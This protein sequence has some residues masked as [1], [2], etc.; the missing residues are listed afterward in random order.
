MDNKRIQPRI[1]FDADVEILLETGETQAGKL[2]NISSGG[3]YVQTTPPPPYGAK[4]KLVVTLPGVPDKCEIPSIVRWTKGDEGA[5]LQFEH[6]RAI[7]VWALTKLK[8]SQRE[9]E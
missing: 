7:E 1:P 2:T 5:G 6:L 4:I 3:T 9:T 8:H